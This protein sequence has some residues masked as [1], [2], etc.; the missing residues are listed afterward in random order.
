M[1]PNNAF[2]RTRSLVRCRGLRLIFR[3]LLIGAM[4][5]SEVFY[6][7]KAVYGGVQA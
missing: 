1:Q 3:T 6:G 7:K 5:L 4:M 2:E